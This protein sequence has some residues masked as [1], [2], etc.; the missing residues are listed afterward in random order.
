MQEALLKAIGWRSRGWKADVDGPGVVISSISVEKLRKS[1]WW[2][3]SCPPRCKK[4]PYWSP[5]GRWLVSG[6]Y[7]NVVRI[8]D[9]SSGQ[10]VREM[11]GHDGPVRRLNWHPTDNR[12]ATVSPDGTLRIWDPT[13]GR[14]LLVL[15]GQSA[16]AWSHDGRRIAAGSK[17]GRVRI[18]EASSPEDI[19]S[20]PSYRKHLALVN[21]QRALGL[22]ERASPMSRT[23][24]WTRLANWTPTLPRDTSTEHESTSAKRTTG[25]PWSM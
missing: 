20:K 2:P 10:Q 11:H 19:S 4:R 23:P 9:S 7:D 21:V 1:A 3:R 6:A 16:V 12:L 8:W 17:E 22:V 15:R 18:Y 13:N 25:T 24:L 14:Q 5:D